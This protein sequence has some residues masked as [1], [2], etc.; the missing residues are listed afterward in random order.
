MFNTI[1]NIEKNS[2]S[3]LIHIFEENLFCDI[4]IFF[5]YEKLF[6][7]ISYLTWFREPGKKIVFFYG[8]LFINNWKTALEEKQYVQIANI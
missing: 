8:I 4:H 2:G 1:G 6:T 3:M 7:D 5:I